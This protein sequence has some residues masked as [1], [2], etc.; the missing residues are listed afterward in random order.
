MI[1]N[2]DMVG[3]DDTVFHDQTYCSLQDRGEKEYNV[4]ERVKDREWKKRL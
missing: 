1:I 3:Y 2:V 4:G